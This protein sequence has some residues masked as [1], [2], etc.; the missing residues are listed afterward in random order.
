MA[1]PNTLEGQKALWTTVLNGLAPA[2]QDADAFLMRDPANATHAAEYQKLMAPQI[3]ETGTDMFGN[4]THAAYFPGS[5]SLKSLTFDQG[6][7][8]AGGSNSPLA[9]ASTYG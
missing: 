5:T 6:Q 9:Q 7:S 4:K 1:D 3:V 8:G 2:L